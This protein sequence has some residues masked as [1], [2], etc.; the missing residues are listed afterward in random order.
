MIPGKQLPTCL[1]CLAFLLPK[2][3]AQFPATDVSAAAGIQH[4]YLGTTHLGGGAAFFDMDNDGD[5]D[6]WI[7]GGLNMDA[8]YRNNG[9]GTFT[10]IAL[11]AGIWPTNYFVTTG[12]V[13]GDLDNDGFRDVLVLTHTGHRLLLFHNR[14]DLTFSEISIPAGIGA[15]TGQSFAAA[16]AD[17]N[18][19]GLLDAYVGNYIGQDQLVYNGNTVVGFAHSCQKNW[20]L[21]N[22][23]ANTFSEAAADYGVADMGCTLAATFSDV[24]LDADPDLLVVN[25]FGEWVAPNAL[26][27]NAFPADSFPDVSTTAGMDLAIYG[28]GVATGDFD[29]D[30]D[31]DFY[32][33]NIG[34][35]ALLVQQADGTFLDKAADTGT[36][37]TFID[38]LRTAG[39]ATAFLDADNDSDL[40][41]FVCNGYIPAAGFIATSPLNRN[42]L[43]LNDG[44]ESGTGFLFT[45]AA[46]GSPLADPG[47]GRGFA[48]SDYDNDGDLDFLV[49]RLNRQTSPDTIQ[50]VSLYRNDSDN[51]NHWLKIKLEGGSAN[52]DAFGS[53]IRVHLGDKAWIHDYNGGFGG[54]ASQH[55]STAHFGLGTSPSV[56]SVIITW[57]GGSVTRLYQVAGNQ[58]LHIRQE[59]PV[60]LALPFPPAPLEADV[61]PNPVSAESRLRFR[62]PADGRTEIC[63]FDFLGRKRQTIFSDWLPAGLH[64]V[65]CRPDG[66]FPAGP[67]FLR[68]RQGDRSAT[69]SLSYFP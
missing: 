47:R 39:W 37:D 66:S 28:M 25:D 36:A 9:D 53:T 44:N 23:A 35:N 40:D 30:Q 14:G 24:D 27:R 50:P 5:D 69:L 63:L 59:E 2:A 17:V 6:L 22:N 12:V 57:P 1:C 21:V 10:D 41:L 4:H 15:L 56:D 52:R 49:V 46:P 67:C 8:L 51:G 38:S 31:L 11:A 48:Y 45:D 29:R 16:L 3:G 61:V 42:R 26:F 43:F 60:A 54:F 18:L 32:F 58:V 65:P 20:L 62:L 34:S 7:T 64:T 55:S 13:T 19:D 68:I 33:T